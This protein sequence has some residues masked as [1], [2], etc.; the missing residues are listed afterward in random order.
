MAPMLLGFILGDILEKNLSRTLTLTDGSYAFLWERPLTLTIMLLALL[1]LLLPVF[2]A[3]WDKKRG[4]KSS[5][6]QA[7][8]HATD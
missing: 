6:T 8:E 3:V 7:T 2:I 4:K 5:T 1:A